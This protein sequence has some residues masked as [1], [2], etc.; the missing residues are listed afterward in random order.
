LKKYSLTLLLAT[1]ILIGVGFA[2]K[3]RRSN[4]RTPEVVVYVSEDRVFAEPILKDFEKQT[5]IRV[6]AVYDTE[7]AKS[8]GVMNRLLASSSTRIIFFIVSPLHL[9]ATHVAYCRIG[10]N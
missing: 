7:E 9:K 6:Q 4:S 8:N 3:A 2:C 5:G 10:K 1:L